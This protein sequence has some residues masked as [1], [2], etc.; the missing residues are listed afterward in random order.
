M[1]I[2]IIVVVAV[3]VMIIVIVVITV[4]G[5]QFIGFHR[6]SYAR[7]LALVPFKTPRA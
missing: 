7:S 6:S 5:R 4:S 1:I 2:I 3:Y